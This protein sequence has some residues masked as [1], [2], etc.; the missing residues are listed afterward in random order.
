MSEMSR[1]S[2][3]TFCWVELG[4]T[5]AGAA[6]RFYSELLG[7]ETEDSAVGEWIYTMLRRN[8]KDVGGL[9]QLNKEMLALGVPP[10]WMTYVAVASAD[11]TTKKAASLGGKVLKDPFDVMDVGRMSTLQDPTGATFSLWQPKKHSGAGITSEIGTVCWNELATT[12]TG[13]A[14]KFYTQLFGW[15]TKLQDVGPTKYM[16]FMNGEMPTGG[17]LQMTPEW[18]AIPPH[19]TIYFTVND[20]N[21]RT[22]LSWKILPAS[23]R[24]ARRNKSRSSGLCRVVLL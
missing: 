13:V 24:N 1:Y 21:P 23:N 5:N 6:K 8:G 3:G 12:D 16:M 19:W 10:H 14:G 7:W 15:R 17:M 2:P 9:Y 20:W 11:E 22:P 4:T 18:G